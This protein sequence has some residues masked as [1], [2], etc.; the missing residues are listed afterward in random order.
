MFQIFQSQWRTKKK[1]KIIIL[2]FVHYLYF[3][4]AFSFEFIFLTF[5]TK[6]F[7]H[8]D[9]IY[10]LDLTFY[11]PSTIDILLY[12]LYQMPIYQ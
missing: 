5:I 4:L 11:L 9:S 3:T 1:S 7:K 8:T 6:M 2:L 10:H 12:L